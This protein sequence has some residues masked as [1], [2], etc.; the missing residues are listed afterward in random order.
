MQKEEEE[1]ERDRN[2]S[3]AAPLQDGSCNGT[4]SSVFGV[5]SF[6]VV[7]VVVVRLSP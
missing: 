7:G 1:R 6:V 5:G 4:Q 2:C 3:I